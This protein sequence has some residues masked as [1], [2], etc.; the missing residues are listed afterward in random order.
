MDLGVPNDLFIADGAGSR[1]RG[2]VGSESVDVGPSAD[3]IAGY[4]HGAPLRSQGVQGGARIFE[5]RGRDGRITHAVAGTASTGDATWALPEIDPTLDL[6]DPASIERYFGQPMSQKEAT[7]TYYKQQI[8]KVLEISPDDIPNDAFELGPTPFTMQSH[9]STPVA[10]D[11]KNVHLIGDARGNSHFFASL[12]KGTGTGPH[13]MAILLYFQALR[14]G[15]NP[16][17]ARALLDHRLDAA[18]RVWLKS[19]LPS[20]TGFAHPHEAGMKFKPDPDVATEVPRAPRMQ[21]T[22]IRRTEVTPD[23]GLGRDDIGVMRSLRGASEGTEA[24]RGA[25]TAATMGKAST[26]VLRDP[27][28]VANFANRVKAL[29]EEWPTMSIQQREAA[30]G[31]AINA[32]LREAGLPEVRVTSG[33]IKTNAHFDAR[34]WSIVLRGDVVSDHAIGGVGLQGFVDTVFHEARHAEQTYL[35]ARYASET[36]MGRMRIRRNMRGVPRA[37]LDAAYSDTRPL[38][39]TQRA[40]GQRMYESLYGSG[41]RHSVGVMRSFAK[42]QHD[43][44]LAF[45]AYA[46][47]KDDP[48]VSEAKK[49]RLNAKLSEAADRADASERAYRD[50]PH[51]VDAYEVGD[52]VKEVV[53]TDYWSETLGT[54][55]KPLIVPDSEL[56]VPQEVRGYRVDDHKQRFIDRGTFRSIAAGETHDIPASTRTAMQGV[57]LAKLNRSLSDA[58]TAD[59]PLKDAI[60]EKLP[61]FENDSALEDDLFD[62]LGELEQQQLALEFLLETFHDSGDRAL[63]EAASVKLNWVAREGLQSGALH[64]AAETRA[65][66]QL[67]AAL[68]DPDATIVSKRPVPWDQGAYSLELSNGVLAHWT[69]GRDSGSGVPREIDGVMGTALVILSRHDGVDESAATDEIAGDEGVVFE[70]VRRKV[71]PLWQ[72]AMWIELGDAR[73]EQDMLLA[74][75]NGDM[76]RYLARVGPTSDHFTF[77]NRIDASNPHRAFAFATEP[78]DLRGLT[79]AE[80]L[81]KV[82]WTRDWAKLNIGKDIQISILDTHAKS[83]SDEET[84]EPQL[85]VTKAD[86]PALKAFALADDAFLDDIEARS[87]APYEASELFDQLAAG[88][89]SSAKMEAML[90]VLRARYG[91]NDLYTGTGAT[92]DAEGALGAREVM[93]QSNGT[94]VSADTSNLVRVSVGTLTQD[95]FDR[96]FGVDE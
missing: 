41:A 68:G 84:H 73:S 91:V 46:K 15:M 75:K 44:L 57:A 94:G 80:A 78:A 66:Q 89:P 9:V 64:G 92:T 14:W 93:V 13:E 81:F 6:G 31:D 95:D 61:Q 43:W 47:V 3:F 38:T 62:G 52:A 74:I 11:A 59:R 77:A 19:G 30:I 28:E 24:H 51:E 29:R 2:M 69:P 90:E 83:L 34:I 36:G 33:A 88:G 39:P 65:I 40:L 18:T 32:T 27:H 58:S 55:E 35:A 48:R 54:P 16:V 23:V 60:A 72:Q 49:E 71:P 70:R 17:V 25:D 79:P 67:R 21:E 12:G 45:R 1:L 76:P 56:G 37:I 63:R 10:D 26:D 87:I 86:W 5:E 50:L 7:L 42:D 8:A 96:V 4:F 53:P 82:G 85:V 20:L 22:E